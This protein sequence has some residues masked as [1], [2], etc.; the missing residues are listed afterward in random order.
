MKAAKANTATKSYWE[1]NAAELARATSEFDREFVVD[2]FGAPSKAAK[3]RLDRSNRKRGR[4]K[5]GKGVKVISV[6]LEKNLLNQTDKLAKKL[7]VSRARLISHGLK[8]V[9]AAQPRE[10]S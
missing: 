6:S 3:A 2:E 1:M 9:L 8:A 4:P 7:R 5:L 10:A